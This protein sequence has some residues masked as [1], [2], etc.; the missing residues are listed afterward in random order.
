MGRPRKRFTRGGLLALAVLGALGSVVAPAHAGE[1]EPLRSALAWKKPV[2]LRLSG[3]TCDELAHVVSQQLMTRVRAT[4]EVAERRVTIVAPECTLR[5]LREGLL[6]QFGL[7]LEGYSSSESI[8]FRLRPAPVAKPKPRPGQAATRPTAK[9]PAPAGVAATA[10]KTT[11]PAPAGALPSDP[12]LEERLDL[13]QVT[14]EEEFE[15]LPGVLGYLSEATQICVMADVVPRAEECPG[16]QAVPEFVKQLDGLSLREALDRTARAFGY[17]W[18]RSG[19]WFLFR[20][21]GK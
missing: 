4:E 11:Q 19:R 2:W 20:A 17:T 15:G 6:A 10:L 16:G 9:K 14:V 13:S 3:E 5:E 8:H 1:H 7:L 18:T 12:R 21:R